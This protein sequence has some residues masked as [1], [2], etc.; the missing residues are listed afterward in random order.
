MGTSDSTVLKSKVR[1]I[2]EV[3]N[4]VVSARLK[5]LEK[6]ENSKLTEDGLQIEGASLHLGE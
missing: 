2:I 1:N 4:G 5:I 6:T 3:S